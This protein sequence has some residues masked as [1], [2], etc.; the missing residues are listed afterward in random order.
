MGI[1]TELGNI[2][3]KANSA[4]IVQN[5]LRQKEPDLSPQAS[6]EMSKICIN[7]CWEIYPDVFNGTF[8]QRPH[9]IITALVG[10]VQVLN[11]TER[12]NQ[13]FKLIFLATINLYRDIL[14]NDV[15]SIFSNIDYKMIEMM[16]PILE[17]EIADFENKSKEIAD[18]INTLSVAN[19]NEDIHHSE[20]QKEI[21]KRIKIF[22]DRYVV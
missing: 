19:E 6:K 21:A 10:M 15:S 1:I 2:W 12:D 16:A 18:K 17:D 3:V 4:I 8:E 11:S 5:Y 22:K 9:K 13:S 20:K 14:T 7:K